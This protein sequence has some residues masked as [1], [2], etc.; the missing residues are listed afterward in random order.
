MPIRPAAFE[1]AE[2]HSRCRPPQPA[3]F[4]R[5]LHPAAHH[6][7]HST[8]R[9]AEREH[10]DIQF[11]TCSLSSPPFCETRI[12]RVPERPSGPREPAWPLRRRRDRHA[13]SRKIALGAAIDSVEEP[14]ANWN[15]VQHATDSA[16]I[17]IVFAPAAVSGRSVRQREHG[18]SRPC[19]SAARPRREAERPGASPTS[20]GAPRRVLRR[21]SV[22]LRCGSLPQARP[23]PAGHGTAWIIALSRS[24]LIR[25]SSSGGLRGHGPLLGQIVAERERV[26]QAGAARQRSTRALRPRSAS[27]WTSGSASPWVDHRDRH[28]RSQ[29]QDEQQRQCLT[30]RAHR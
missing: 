15:E 11:V 4:P 28:P 24:S 1:I 3:L 18:P 25:G 14:S 8:R 20:T 19:R 22:T 23:L 10:S 6:I 5:T 27:S 13:S 9:R 30:R 29:L 26:E 7:R 16:L 21:R 2:M 17:G 12:S